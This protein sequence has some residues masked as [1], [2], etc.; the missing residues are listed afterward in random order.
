MDVRTIAGSHDEPRQAAESPRVEG[1]TP[2]LSADLG[3]VPEACLQVQ[4]WYFAQ[5]SLSLQSL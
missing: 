3:N 5:Q 4:G 2:F 1:L